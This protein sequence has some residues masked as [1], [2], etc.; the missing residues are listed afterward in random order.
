M[1]STPFTHWER[2]GRAAGKPVE[3]GTPGRRESFSYG[4]AMLLSKWTGAVSSD[5]SE[6]L[7]V[8]L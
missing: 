7:L 8:R 2:Q 5:L 4:R 6:H 3:M 1:Q